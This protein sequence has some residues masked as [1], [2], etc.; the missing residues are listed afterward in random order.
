MGLRFGF[1]E[2][3]VLL[4]EVPGHD[5][6]VKFTRFM[7]QAVQMNSKEAYDK[8]GSGYKDF[9]ASD[10]FFQK[11]YEE[12]GVMYFKKEKASGGLQNLLSSLE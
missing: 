6:F 10:S 8:I 4:S 1:D 7:I 5:P 9:L 12:Y 3:M 11:I 2:S